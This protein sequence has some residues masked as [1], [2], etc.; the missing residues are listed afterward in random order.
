MIKFINVEVTFK[1]KG[2][3]VEAVKNAT[4]EINNGE[5]FGIVGT[6]GAGKSTLLRTINLLQRPTSGTVIVNG[7]EITNYKGNELRSLRAGIGMIFQHFNLIHTKTVFENV[8]FAMKAAGKSKEEIKNRVPEVLELVGLSDRA[9][10]FPSTLSGG[11]KQRVGIARAIANN[12]SILLCDEATSALDLE[13]TNAILQLL[14]EINQKL[15]IT[16]VII[17]HEMHVIK[18]I[19]DRVA[20]MTDGDVVELDDIFSVFSHP[21][22]E[23][24]KSL[25]NHTINLELPAR[26]LNNNGKRILKIIYSGEKAEEAVLSDTIRAFKVN[27]NILHGKIEYI[28]N[29]PFGILIVQLDGLTEDVEIAEK[30]LKQRTFN[31]EVIND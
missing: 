8:A 16:T 13:T 7:K 23:Y 12:P 30:Y 25:V 14:R 29:K 1:G 6:S 28:T 5:I 26:L 17:S 11:Q 31:V 2:K 4:F 18:S 10:A 19:C 20:V 9:S 24:T 3:S 15:G 27:I 21:K 22:H